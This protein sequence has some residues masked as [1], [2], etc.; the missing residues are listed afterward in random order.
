MSTQDRNTLAHKSFACRAMG[1]VAMAGAAVLLAAC[2]SGNDAGGGTSTDTSSTAVAVRATGNPRLGTILVDASGKTL[3]FADQESD[4][5]IRCVGDCLGFW[6]PAAASGG[7]APDVPGVTALGVVRRGDD[8][9][10]QLTLAGKPLYTFQLDG[11]AGDTKG[12]GVQDEFGTTHFG[13]HAATVGG[14]ATPT[15]SSTPAA[16]GGYGGGY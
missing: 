7:T 11:A 5:T 1:L 3:Y 10:G 2:G 13:W 12:D 9:K 15:P 14:G 16:G 6:S 8:G 4:G